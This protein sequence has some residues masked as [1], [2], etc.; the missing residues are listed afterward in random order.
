MANKKE[1]PKDVAQALE[2]GE[3]EE[4]SGGYIYGEGAP[5]LEWEVVDDG[6]GEVLGRY[7]T[8]EEAITMAW[9]KGQS[10]KRVYWHG[11]QGLFR[12]RELSK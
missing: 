11:D 9:R 4:V 12:L 10:P 7:E 8:K 6:N 5:G 3:L 1:L 2:N